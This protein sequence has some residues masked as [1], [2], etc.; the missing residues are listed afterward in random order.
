M[1]KEN[2]NA[3][4]VLTSGSAILIFWIVMLGWVQWPG[5]CGAS[6]P[7]QINFEELFSDAGTLD[8]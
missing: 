6:D 8:E 4:I 5:H 1:K 7:S 3:L 2:K